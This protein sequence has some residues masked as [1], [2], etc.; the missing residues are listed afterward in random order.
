MFKKNESAVDTVEKMLRVSDV[1]KLLPIGRSTLFAWVSRDEF[2]KPRKLGRISFWT[3]SD[4]LEWQASLPRR[5]E[6]IA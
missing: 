1:L 4:I 6:E 3:E 5:G 2:P